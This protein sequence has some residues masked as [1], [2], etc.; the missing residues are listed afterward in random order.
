[1][2]SLKK[3][4]PVNTLRDY[5]IGK[6][7][8]IIH[9]SEYNTSKRCLI[10]GGLTNKKRFVMYKDGSVYPSHGVLSCTECHKTYGRDYN[11]AKNILHI[12]YNYLHTIERPSWLQKLNN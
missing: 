3:E 9:I 11:G 8:N 1:M 5:L 12:L 6:N 2:F 10:C 7:V 4:S